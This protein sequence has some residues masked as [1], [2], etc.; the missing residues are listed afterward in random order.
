MPSPYSAP[1]MVYA[2]LQAKGVTGN[3]P[4]TAGRVA[5]RT[6]TGYGLSVTGAANDLRHDIALVATAQRLVTDAYLGSSPVG[7][8]EEA[9]WPYIGLESYNDPE[10]ATLVIAASSQEVAFR[11]SPWDTGRK[12]PV[13]YGPTFTDF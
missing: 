13:V 1:L 6:S 2:L 5:G 7:L 3:P 10:F 8:S 11:P 12:S 4:I 9:G